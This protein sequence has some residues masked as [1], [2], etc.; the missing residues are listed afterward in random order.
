MMNKEKRYKE[1]L[2]IIMGKNGSGSS[3]LWSEMQSIAEYALTGNDIGETWPIEEKDKIL[4]DN[5]D[6]IPVIWN[7]QRKVSKN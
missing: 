3:F 6:I 7:R 5:A 2:K 1:S 4:I